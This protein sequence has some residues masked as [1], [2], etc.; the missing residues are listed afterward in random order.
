[1]KSDIAYW[2]KKDL[3]CSTYKSDGDVSVDPDQIRK[4]DDAAKDDLSVAQK[5]LHQN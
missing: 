2:S 3:V 5:M 4:R 1:M